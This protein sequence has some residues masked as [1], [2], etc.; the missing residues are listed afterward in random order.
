MQTPATYPKPANELLRLHALYSYD[1]L[2]SISE[3]EYDSITKLASQICGTPVSFISFIDEGRQWYKSSFG[4]ELTEIP[5]EVSLCNYTILDNEQVLVVPDLRND[6]RFANNPLVKGHP[7]AVFY[8]GTSLVT[9]EGHALGTICTLDSKVNHLN[10]N[11]VE[12]L[13]S[14]A[15]QVMARLELHKKLKELSIAQQQLKEVNADL[16]SF[17][18]IASHDMKTPLAN[19]SM[20]SRAFQ[21][22]YEDSFDEDAMKYLTL[23]DGSAKELLQFIGNILTKSKKMR[24]GEDCNL[25]NSNDTIKKVISMIVPPPDIEINVQGALP[26]IAMDQIS[27]QQVFQNLITNA[28]KYNNKEKGVINIW[29]E[30]DE[31]FH[32]FNIQD[33]G[34]GID[35][36]NFDKIFQNELT[37]QTTDRYGNQGTG[38]GLSTVKNIIE[39]AGGDIAVESEKDFGSVFQ[40][41]IPR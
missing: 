14:L 2:D 34:R 22:R 18:N 6:E 1:I 11:Q 23:I 10:E 31:N 41:C 26:D 24:T 21:Q 40:F 27:L 17:A 36:E 16:K 29:S 25:V 5:R 39:S 3:K 12:A 30:S 38:I 15:E 7:N 32:R 35:R 9:K 8:A 20:M 4:F 37:L 33:N 13:K 19:I 28:I